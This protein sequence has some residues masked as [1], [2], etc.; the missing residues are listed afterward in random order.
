MALTIKYFKLY[1]SSLSNSY[2]YICKFKLSFIFIKYLDYIFSNIF[3]ILIQI[4]FQILYQYLLN[5]MAKY[6]HLCLII[7]KILLFIIYI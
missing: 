5:Y 6:T 4:I 2:V 7:L 1:N 3:L